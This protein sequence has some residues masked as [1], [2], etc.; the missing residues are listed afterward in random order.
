MMGR[1]RSDMIV[2][3]GDCAGTL[4]TGRTVRVTEIF[5]DCNIYVYIYVY[6]ITRQCDPDILIHA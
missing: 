5:T 6:N 4:L 3:A 2:T 1:Y